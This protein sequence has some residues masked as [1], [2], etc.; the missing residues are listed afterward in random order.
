MSKLVR[1]I[2]RLTCRNIEL[3]QPQSIRP[4]LLLQELQRR[5]HL[6]LNY[7]IYKIVL[8]VSH[9]FSY[10]DSSQLCIVHSIPDV[11]ILIKE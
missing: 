10:I 9:L 7:L 3:N 11:L 4:S 2:S 1:E 5:P 6:W 8:Y